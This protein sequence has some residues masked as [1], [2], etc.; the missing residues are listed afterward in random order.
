MQTRSKFDIV[1]VKQF[2]EFTS[3]H[4]QLSTI[5]EPNAPSNFKQTF[6]HP[7]WQHAMYEE[8]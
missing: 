4:T 6:G 3:F 8:I 5:I 1:Q 7:A 2:L